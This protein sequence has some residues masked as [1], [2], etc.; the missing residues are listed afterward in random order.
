MKAM[1]HALCHG[2][3]CACYV[4]LALWLGHAACVLGFLPSN[5][6]FGREPATSFECP[7]R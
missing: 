1:V 6:E 2:F 5:K 4:R 7:H 3:F